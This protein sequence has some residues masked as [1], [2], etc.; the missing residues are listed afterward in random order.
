[1]SARA[2]RTKTQAHSTK[3]FDFFTPFMGNL[4]RPTKPF[5]NLDLKFGFTFFF[6]AGPSN[7]DFTRRGGDIHSVPP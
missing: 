4:R 7:R 1:M 2:Q 3:I 6:R 5:E